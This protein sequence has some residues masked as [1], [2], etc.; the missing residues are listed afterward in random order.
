VSHAARRALPPARRGHGRLVAGV[1]GIVLSFFA[2]LLAGPVLGLGT[3]THDLAASANA[4]PTLIAPTAT[5]ARAAVT[6]PSAKT[7]PTPADCKGAKDQRRTAAARSKPFLVCGVALIN[8]SHRVSTAYRP[9]LVT[10]AVKASGVPNVRLQPVAG[11]A[12]VRLFRAARKAGYPLVVRSSYRSFATQ[13]TWYATMN[14]TLTAPAGASEHQS[15]LAVDLAGI[16]AGRLVR[17]TALGSSRTGAWLLTHAADYGFILRY[18]TS[19]SKI[20]GIAYEPWHFRYVGIKV[21]KAVNATKTKTLERYL[22][23]A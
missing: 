6:T 17:G 4:V 23:E 16:Q 2:G 7:S 3:G 5:P 8:K 22:E 14:K 1:L 10:V 18:P 9:K 21:A 20:T 13:A 11:T 19:Q 12:L 15:G